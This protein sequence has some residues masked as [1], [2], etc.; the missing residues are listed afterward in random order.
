MQ[1]RSTAAAPLYQ[2]AFNYPVSITPKLQQFL[3]DPL[4]QQG[5]AQ[6]REVQRLEGL[7]GNPVPLPNSIWGQLDA[8]KRGL[9]DIVE[10]YRD[11]TTGRLALDQRGRAVD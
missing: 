4:I 11:P 6:G 2:Q 10:K 7:A 8:A 5:L 9:D 1:Q 3:G